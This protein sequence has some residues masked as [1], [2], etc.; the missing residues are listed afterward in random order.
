MGAKPLFEVHF[1]VTEISLS[2]AADLGGEKHDL[3]YF[4]NSTPTSSQEDNRR[5]L[6]TSCKACTQ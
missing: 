6:R 3:T 2:Q 4:H 1:A 5:Q